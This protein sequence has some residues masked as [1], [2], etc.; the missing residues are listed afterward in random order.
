MRKDRN[1]ANL[2]A[3]DCIAQALI[4]LMKQKKY[5]DITITDLAKTAGVWSR[6][7]PSDRSPCPAGTG[8]KYTARK[9]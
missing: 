1:P 9:D 3:K 7:H 6:P 8:R 4:K 2:F 5:E